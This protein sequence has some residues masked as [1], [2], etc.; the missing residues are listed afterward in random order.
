MSEKCMCTSDPVTWSER[1]KK[2]HSK[3]Q[4]K[5]GN[6]IIR[7]ENV[8]EIEIEAKMKFRVAKIRTTAG[9]GKLISVK[10]WFMNCEPK[11]VF[12]S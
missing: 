8:N 4:R 1:G 3:L 2:N 7:E 12:E 5:R 11:N 10:S 9:R 6:I